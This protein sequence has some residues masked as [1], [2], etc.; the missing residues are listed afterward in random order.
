MIENMKT[1]FE[2]AGSLGFGAL[3]TLIYSIAG[4]ITALSAAVIIL[5]NSVHRGRIPQ[6]LPAAAVLIIRSTPFLLFLY[7]IYYGLPAAG[8]VI[9]AKWCAFGAIS[10]YYTFYVFEIL[11]S[12]YLSLPKDQFEAY[13]A[14]GYTEIDGFLGVIL[15]QA[16]RRS[17]SLLANNSII[18]M[19]DTSFFMI[20]G[21]ADLTYSANEIQAVYFIPFEPFLV[22]VFGYWVISMLLN[23]LFGEKLADHLGLRLV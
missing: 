18:L 16:Y 12:A 2:H 22:A 23:F 17:A 8:L 14:C 10:I 7:L 15:P 19:K 4:Y 21:I 11:R 13:R 9:S 5:Y 1:V 3:T 6:L 20:I